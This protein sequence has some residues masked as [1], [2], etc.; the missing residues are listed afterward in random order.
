MLEIVIKLIG[1]LLVLAGIILVYDARIITKKFF[2]FGDQNDAAKR[3]KNVRIYNSYSRWINCIFCIKTLDKTKI[4]MLILSMLVN[5]F[6]CGCGGTGRRA[7]LRNQCQRRGG[8][9]PFIRTNNESVR[10]TDIKSISKMVDFLVCKFSI[11]CFAELKARICV[12][13]KSHCP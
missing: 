10:T 11:Y 2:G 12:I 9:S 13:I 7:G 8:S 5:N 3:I 6:I 1:V 4:F